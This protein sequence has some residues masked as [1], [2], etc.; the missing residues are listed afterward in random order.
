ME[1]R[2][3]PYH[4]LRTEK[5]FMVHSEDQPGSL[6]AGLWRGRVFGIARQGV[7]G[8]SAILATNC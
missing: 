4:V 8:G 7:A 5:T 6:G 1:N 3:D 2:A